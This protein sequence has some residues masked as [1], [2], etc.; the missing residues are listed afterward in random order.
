MK[1]FSIIIASILFSAMSLTSC[2]SDDNNN[3]TRSIVGKWN[4]ISQKEIEGGQVV[5]DGPYTDH[6]SGCP[7]DY[8]EFFENGSAV[9]ATYDKIDN[10]CELDTNFT[11]Y[12]T[13]GDVLSIN[14]GEE[15][16]TVQIVES[17]NSTLVLKLSETYMGV[18]EERVFTLSKTN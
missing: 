1:K 3:S 9:D 18:L 6:E 4:F 10:V 2:S 13:N 16:V 7:L 11:T 12:T 17:S 8:L 14:N 15:T 5:Y